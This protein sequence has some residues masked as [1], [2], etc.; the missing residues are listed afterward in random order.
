AQVSP[1]AIR[2]HPPRKHLADIHKG[3]ALQNTRITDEHCG[4]V[5]PRYRKSGLC[6]AASGRT[7]EIPK[8]TVNRSKYPLGAAPLT[9]R[10]RRNL[11]MPENLREE[12]APPVGGVGA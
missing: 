9:E 2:R 12:N 7:R 10:E 4:Q 3:A 8:T 5:T 1:A 11:E 6:E